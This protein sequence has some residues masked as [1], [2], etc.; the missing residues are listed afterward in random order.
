MWPY[1]LDGFASGTVRNSF[2]L[3][4][5]FLLTGACARHTAAIAFPS[6]P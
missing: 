3:N 2:A 5:M 6:F 4:S 1:W